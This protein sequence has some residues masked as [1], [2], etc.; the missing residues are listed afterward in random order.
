MSIL[1]LD[2]ISE[3]PPL[4]RLASPLQRALP[5]LIACF[6]HHTDLAAKLTGFLSETSP[7][8]EKELP[9]ALLELVNRI[10]LLSELILLSETLPTPALK[11]QALQKIALLHLENSRLKG[12]PIDLALSCRDKI[13]SPHFRDLISY[14]ALLVFLESGHIDEALKLRETL[15]IHPFPDLASAQTA[16][17]LAKKGAPTRALALCDQIHSPQVKLDTREACKKIILRPS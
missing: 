9:E 15:T 17:A 8:I 2:L 16:L 4:R 13:T 10:E 5:P 1:P 7:R 6:R 3:A 11:Q 12:T 14:R